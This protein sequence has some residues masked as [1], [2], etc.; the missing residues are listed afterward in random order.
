MVP[1][2]VVSPATTITFNWVIGSKGYKVVTKNV[3]APSGSQEI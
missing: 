1:K 3:Y 2:F